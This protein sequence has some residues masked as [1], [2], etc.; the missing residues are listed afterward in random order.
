MRRTGLLGLIL[1]AACSPQQT[2]STPSTP[3]ATTSPV[4]T[5]PVTT[6]PVTTTPVGDGEPP[7]GV[8]ARVVRVFDG[9]SLKVTIDGRDDEVR[10]LGINAPEP[11]ECFADAA[12]SLL[13]DA[14][15]DAIVI[16]GTER[17]QFGRIIGYAY[18]GATNLNQW[19]VSQGGAIATTRDHELRTDFIAAEQDAILR[20]IGMWSTTTCT[21]GAGPGISIYELEYDAPGRDDENPNGEYVVL[22]NEGPAVDLSRW[23]LRDESSSHRYVF[24][25]GTVL[26]EGGFLIVYS[27]C[28]IDSDEARYWCD[29]GSVWNN[30]GDTAILIDPEGSYVAQY[31]YFGD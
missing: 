27:G 13:A 16:V 25:D 2:V 10:L 23:V 8:D 19:M 6:S 26:A 12:R 4:T 11:D 29:G 18:R 20:G 22:A 7:A 17:D 30:D 14:A 3:G 5:S 21:P 15:G 28:G 9:D 24:P 31:R 1:L